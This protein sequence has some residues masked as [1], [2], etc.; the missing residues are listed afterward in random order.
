MKIETIRL[1]DKSYPRLLKEI[2]NPPKELFVRGST[3]L[4]TGGELPAT[5]KIH[6]AIVGTR[7]ATSEGRI[8]AKKIAR[9]CAEKN[10]VVVS[11]LAMGIDTAAHEGALA[12]GGETIAVLGCGVDTIYPAQNENL[13]NKI[14]DGHGGIISEYTHG[15]PALPHQFLE[16]NRIVAGL[17]IATIVIE[18]PAK[19]GAIVTARLA[20]EYGR[21][22]FVFPGMANHPQ[23]H[24]SH[25]LIRDGAR[26]VNSFEDIL[27]DLEGDS[28][29]SLPEAAS[30]FSCEKPHLALGKLTPAETKLSLPAKHSVRET[31]ESL[32]NV[33]GRNH[34]SER[35][36]PTK[37]AG[38]PE[39]QSAGGAVVNAH[40]GGVNGA[41]EMIS[42]E[43]R[44]I[45]GIIS[46]SKTP[47]SVDNILELTNLEPQMVNRAL[48]E[49]LVSRI[50][51]EVGFGF[52]LVNK[53]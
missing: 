16:R 3:V 19:S 25:A 41:R 45:L 47:I 1:G 38:L 5:E 50:I 22:V 21:E 35:T 6:V 4:T 34:F 24:G 9:Q 12:G 53:E 18:A 51:E 28:F 27:E 32:D 33:R 48:S 8:L 40:A 31:K 30:A 39:G 37:R 10:W 44:N 42:S 7:K 13:A 23:Y 36:S 17:S 43:A 20:A 15:T 26:L 14:L 29:V 52:K 2:S 46:K 49:M 11:G